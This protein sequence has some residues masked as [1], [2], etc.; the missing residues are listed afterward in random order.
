[1]LGILRWGGIMLLCVTQGGK[2][3]KTIGCLMIFNMLF[4]WAPFVIL[5][6]FIS[7][8]FR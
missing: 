3:G 2:V 8:A 5:I 7:Q 6:S 4:G 1:V